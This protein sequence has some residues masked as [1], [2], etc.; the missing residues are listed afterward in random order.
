MPLTPQQQKRF[1]AIGH[2]LKPTVTIAAKGLSESV[3]AE[4]TRALGD[5]ELIK[6]KLSLGD[7][8]QKKSTINEV[9]GLTQASLIQKIGNIALIYRAAEKSNSKLSNLRLG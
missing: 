8:E 2:K 1:R 4:I 9:C 6:I 3:I 5:H 7:R